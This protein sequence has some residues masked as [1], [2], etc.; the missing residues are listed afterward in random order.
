MKKL[1]AFAVA[2]LFFFHA[3]ES[4]AG[5]TPIEV[6]IEP[7]GDVQTVNEGDPYPGDSPENIHGALFWNGSRW[8]TNDTAAHAYFHNLETDRRLKEY[9]VTVVDNNPA[10]L[11]T[12]AA[13]PGYPV[14]KSLYIYTAPAASGTGTYSYQALQYV[15]TLPD[16]TKVILRSRGT[17]HGTS[18]AYFDVYIEDLG[19]G[20]TNTTAMRGDPVW[21]RYA[22]TTA[23]QA[24]SQT[25]ETVGKI[26]YLPTYQPVERAQYWMDVDGGS[27]MGGVTYHMITSGIV[28]ADSHTHNLEMAF[29]TEFRY[30]FTDAND[31]SHLQD[32]VFQ[33]VI[34]AADSDG[35]GIGDN[36]ETTDGSNPLDRGSYLPVLGTTLCSEW[37]GFLGGMWNIA[38]HVNMSSSTLNVQST[39]YD[40]SGTGAGNANFSIATGAQLDL[41][42]HDMSGWIHN[43]YGKVC[44]TASAASA[45]DLDGR[46]VYYK[47]A[48]GS[49]AP[50]YLFEF[51]FAMP[52]LNG[53]KGQQVVPFNTFQP[54]LDPV[55]IGKFV[56]NWIQ[57]T[58]LEATA[59]TGTLIFWSQSGTELGRQAVSLGAQARSDY[60]G[61]QFGANLVGIV[62]W[63]PDNPN[64]AFQLRNVRYFYDNAGTADTFMAA[65][66]LEGMVGSGELLAVPL[67]ASIGSAILE[68][69]NSSDSPISVVVDIYNAS[70]TLLEEKSH[71]LPAHGSEH[72]ITDTILNG[73]QGAA[74]IRGSALESVVATAMQYGRNATLGINYLYGIAAKQ[75]LGTVLRSSYNTFLNQGCHLLLVNPGAAAAT[76]TVSMVRYDGTNVLPGEQLSVSAHGLVDYNLCVKDAADNYGVATV[77]AQTANTLVASVVRLGANDTYR[78][79]T[80]V[81]Q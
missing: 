2:C 22:N 36:Q 24:V 18:Q 62:E 51:A 55:D 76:A 68:L 46:M 72:V 78:F 3:A 37:N 52:F 9:N 4:Q 65:F 33:P 23:A 8:V 70:G 40:I 38:E 32:L 80:P 41:L 75:A 27:D 58:N 1:A 35:D 10:N 48:A 6:N 81:R 63:L 43:S 28:P 7:G 12:A 19:D 11:G 71:S 30:K 57:I 54:S 60:S 13:Y 61:H 49:A 44:S 73:A 25:D 17:G 29:V 34:A 26:G 42:V 77:Q 45:G 59:Q 66:Q 14:T 67:D 53:I 47:E 21:F 69:A 79:P 5:T 20:V 39:L 15:L 50:N 31:P 74:T 56:A 64:A 16:T